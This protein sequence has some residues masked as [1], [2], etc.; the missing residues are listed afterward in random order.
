MIAMREMFEATAER[1]LGAQCGP[2]VLVSAEQGEW[3]T[4]LWD[5]IEA[6]GLSIAAAPEASG[7]VGASLQDAYVL[8]RAAGRHSAPAPLGEAILANWLLGASGLDAVA[9]PLSIGLADEAASVG[10]RFTGRVEG[11]AWGRVVSHVVTVAGGQALLLSTRDAQIDEGL[12]I[13]REPRDTLR[14]FDAIP[15]AGVALPEGFPPDILL[16]GG[17]MI[18]AAQSAGALE[19]ILETALDH[20]GQ[21][22]QFGKPIGKFQ[23]IQHQIA[24]LSEHAAMT[25]ATAEAAFATAAPAPH[26]LAVA[27][28]KVVAAEAAGAGAAIAHS[29]LGAI[30]F[31]YEH[32]I[33]FATRRLWSWRGEFGSQSYWAK[34]LGEAACAAGADQFW[35]SLTRGEFAVPPHD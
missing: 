13:A 33:H 18:R 3:Q 20:A 5:E 35:P 25:A 16:L 1:L 4:R 21:R 15:V 23:A 2:E 9:G 17:A 8:V 32:A 30:G 14:F 11:V 34:R 7:G 10:E 12:N 26:I 24:L 27:S 22:V 19:L 6:N 28:A 29:V 31:T